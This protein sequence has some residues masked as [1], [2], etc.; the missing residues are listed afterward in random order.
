MDRGA[1]V[2]NEVTARGYVTV[3]RPGHEPQQIDIADV[4]WTMGTIT[5]VWPP[6]AIWP[7]GT[8]IEWTQAPDDSWVDSYSGRGEE[9]DA[10]EQVIA[11]QAERIGR[12]R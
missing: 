1:E 4:E 12:I 6:D 11:E 10:L 8:S 2:V 5:F 3:T 9:L 7:S